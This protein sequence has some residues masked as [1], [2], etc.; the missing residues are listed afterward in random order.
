MERKKIVKVVSLLI[1]VFL[2]F[3]MIPTFF[4]GNDGFQNHAQRSKT[5]FGIV[6]HSDAV[7]FIKQNNKSL[8]H[9]L[10]TNNTAVSI[11]QISLNNIY[12]VNLSFREMP[13]DHR[14][15]IRKS[16]PHYFNGSKYK[17]IIFAV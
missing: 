2:A 1:I 12:S 17:N 6:H 13:T 14:R 9:R 16:I 10:P 8:L 11:N 15:V 7:Y 5:I 4:T 3:Q